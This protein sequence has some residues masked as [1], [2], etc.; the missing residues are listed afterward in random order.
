VGITALVLSSASS[1]VGIYKT[2]EELVQAAAIINDNPAVVAMNGPPQAVDTLGGRVAF[3]VGAFGFAVVG[4]MGMFLVGRHTRAEE[5][6]G[7]SELMRAAVVGRH[8][9]TTAALIVAAATSVVLGAIVAFG[10][11]AFDLPT[12]GSLAFGAALAGVGLVFAGVTAVVVQITEHTRAA[13]GITGAVLGI[14]YV[15]RAAGDV[16]DGTLSWLSPIGWAQAVRAFA[17]ERWWVLMLFLATTA[18]LTYVSFALSARRD[19]GAGLLRPGPGS[20]TA[21]S[22]LVR[23]VGL[24]L[25]L[26][27]AS[28]MGW[29]A[30]LFLTGLAYGSVGK[31]IEDFVGDN[32]DLADMLAQAGGNLTDSFFATALLILA[33]MAAGFAMQSTIRLRSEETAGRAE[34]VLATAISRVRWAGSHLIVAAGGTIVI[35]AM[36]GLGAGLSYGL[37]IGDL[38]QV[39]RLMGAALV[40]VPAVWALIGVAIALFGLVPRATALAWA[41]LGVCVA[42]GF[43]GELLGLPDWVVGASPFDHVP[44]VPAVGVTFGPLLILSAVAAALAIA[45]LTAFRRR[46]AGY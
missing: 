20:P 23:P 9:P 27:R 40:H 6:S 18:V 14:A 34:P 36:A 39:P 12:A 41:A 31:D 29:A 13:Y 4:L 42:I 24:A 5:E 3:E 32:K 1:I 26:Q 45:G 28:L 17:I 33:L 19:F 35:V 22:S 43:L 11:M 25:R 2:K 21:S 8:A 46:D 16:G 44:Q 7:R 37:T 10:L 15:V 38:S 30:G